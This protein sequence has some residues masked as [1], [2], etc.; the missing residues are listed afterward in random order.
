M[1]RRTE[2]CATAPP[3]FAVSDPDDLK[4]IALF[5]AANRLGRPLA[6]TP[7]TPVDRVR[8]LRAAFDATMKDPAFLKDAE[9][10]P[11][12]VDPVSGVDMEMETKRILATPAAII[13]CAKALMQ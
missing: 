7:E 1:S 13:Q 12:D 4:L 5:T 2:A 11:I 6:T 3:R 8:T 9:K 10:A